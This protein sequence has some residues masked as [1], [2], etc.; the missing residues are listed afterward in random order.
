MTTL[1]DEAALRE[2]MSARDPA[3]P[4]WNLL[5]IPDSTGDTRIMWDPRDKLETKIAEDAY[6]TAKDKK[7]LAYT[8]GQD[9]SKDEVITKFDKKLGKIIMARQP[10]GG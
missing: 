7:M 4:A 3:N 2:E 8:V 10:G 6:N 9:G 5:S 1:T